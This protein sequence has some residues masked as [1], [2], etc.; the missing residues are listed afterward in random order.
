MDAAIVVDGETGEALL[1]VARSLNLI[2]VQAKPGEPTC[3][4]LDFT[5]A[6][7]ATSGRLPDLGD[8][9]EPADIDHLRSYQGEQL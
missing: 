3:V 4:D 9:Q 2:G 8:D 6:S 5:A 7:E 1:P